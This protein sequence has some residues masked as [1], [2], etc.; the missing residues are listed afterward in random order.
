METK[1]CVTAV[2]ERSEKNSF[3]DPKTSD[4]GG[5]E[6]FQAPGQRLPWSLWRPLWVKLF[7]CST[8]GTTSE[9]IYT[10]QP[11]EDPML[12]H[13]D[14]VWRK[15]LHVGSSETGHPEGT[16]T[17]RPMMWWSSSWRT[18]SSGRDFTL[19]HWSREKAWGRRN[20]R[21]KIL[22]TDTHIPTHTPPWAAE[23]GKGGKRAR[24]KI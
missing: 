3:A 10:L 7:P 2:R 19:K 15:L 11:M 5:K 12:Q 23:G 4:E 21:D 18:L 20:N 14:V 22:C 8:W 16:A 24:S 6:V 13:M 9:Q 1:C 17:W